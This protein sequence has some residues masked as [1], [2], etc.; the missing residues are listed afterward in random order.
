V[1][2]PSASGGR[3]S[4]TQTCPAQELLLALVY[5][6]HNVIGHLFGLSAGLGENLFR[7]IVPLL[8]EEFP[9]NRSAAEK[10]VRNGRP[11]TGSR[12]D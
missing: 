1:R 12:E 3:R 9:T 8:R 5:S 7:E 6:R 2:G 10:R 4:E 11:D